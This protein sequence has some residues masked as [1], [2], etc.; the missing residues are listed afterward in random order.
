MSYRQH[1]G[2]IGLPFICC[3]LLSIHHNVSKL[4]YGIPDEL[5]YGR[6]GYLYSLLFVQKHLGTEAVDPTIIQKASRQDRKEKM[7]FY[8]AF[9]SLGFKGKDIRFIVLYSPKRSHNLPLLAGLYTRKPFQ[10]LSN[11][12][13]EL[14][15]Y[16]AQAIS[17]AL[18]ILGT[19][20]AA[21]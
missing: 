21:E 5:L 19:H 2:K 13:E 14:A 9:I 15:A 10:S 6:V 16:S 3:R 12:P 17:T 4:E 1:K 20:F 7:G 8:I 18:F 11:Y